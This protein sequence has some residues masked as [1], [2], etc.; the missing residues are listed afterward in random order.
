MTMWNV[1]ESS[2][3]KTLSPAST[4]FSGPRARVPL[5][6]VCSRVLNSVRAVQPVK[7][8]SGM[9]S[10]SGIPVLDDW[11]EMSWNLTLFRFFLFWNALRAKVIVRFDVLTLL[12]LSKP[13]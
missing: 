4:K 7:A 11:L 3:A 13:A 12:S 2:P 8:E 10:S 9:V 5:S 6:L 1:K